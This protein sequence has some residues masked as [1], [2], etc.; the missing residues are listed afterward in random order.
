MAAL[1]SRGVTGIGIDLSTAAIEPRR[2]TFPIEPGWSPTPIAACR[3][4]TAVS[5]SSCV[6]HGRRNPDEAARVLVAAGYLFVAVPAFDDL[7][8]LREVVQDG[9]S[10]TIESASR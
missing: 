8:E 3:C 5:T 4:W 6:L 2:G 10:N 7:I 1:T 9:A